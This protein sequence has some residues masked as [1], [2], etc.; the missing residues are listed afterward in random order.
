M[1][2][3]SEIRRISPFIA[4]LFARLG[5]LVDSRSDTLGV[6]SSSDPYLQIGDF[7]VVGS[8]LGLVLGDLYP[9]LHE[10]LAWFKS[11]REDLRRKNMGSKVRSDGLERGSSSN[12]SMIGAGVD[13]A[14]S[15]LLVHLRLLI[16]LLLLHLF[17]SMLLKKSVP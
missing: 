8:G 13:M 3:S 7:V 17:L 12:V 9:L 16:L 15:G 11:I 4:F 10:S 2:D 5:A 14:T 1:V 6:F